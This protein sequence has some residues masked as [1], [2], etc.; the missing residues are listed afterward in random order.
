[1]KKAKHLETILT[2]V[3]G[4]AVIGWF[5]KNKNMIT[6]IVFVSAIGLFS[7]YLTEKI[8]WLWMKLAYLSGLVMSKVILSVLFFLFLFP[9][10]L[11]SRLFSK[12]DSLQLKRSSGDSYYTVRNHLYTAEDLENPW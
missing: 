11:L 6:V 4:L 7:G 1:M 10:A 5:T 8:H 9:I 2:I 3:L 12:K